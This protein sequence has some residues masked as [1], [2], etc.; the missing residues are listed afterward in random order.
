MSDKEFSPKKAALWALFVLLLVRPLFQL[1]Q[2][3]NELM[4][5][6]ESVNKKAKLT[7]KIFVYQYTYSYISIMVITFKSYN[8]E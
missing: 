5:Y 4:E 2:H 8:N 3:L 6:L 7:I 1:I